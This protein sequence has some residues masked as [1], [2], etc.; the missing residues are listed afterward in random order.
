[1]PIHGKTVV[2]H[3]HE[4]EGVEEESSDWRD[5]VLCNNANETQLAG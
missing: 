5:S 1:M 3:K 2:V 4:V